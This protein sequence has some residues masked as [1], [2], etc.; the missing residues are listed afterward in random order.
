[1][2]HLPTWQRIVYIVITALIAVSMIGL[3]FI[4]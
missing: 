4:Y 3:S 2:K 1:M